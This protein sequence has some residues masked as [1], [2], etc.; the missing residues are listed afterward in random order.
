M[1]E[2]TSSPPTLGVG[3]DEGRSSSDSAVGTRGSTGDGPT[4]WWPRAT[5]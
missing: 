3:G 1:V 5:K 2:R 4:R